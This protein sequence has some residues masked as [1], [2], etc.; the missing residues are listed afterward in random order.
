MHKYTAHNA[1]FLFHSIEKVHDA[2]KHACMRSHRND[3]NDVDGD[4]GLRWCCCN[5]IKRRQ[6]SFDC[7]LF[8]TMYMF[9][10]MVE[11]LKNGDRTKLGY[12]KPYTHGFIY[13]PL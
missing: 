10:L 8:S 6:D 7:S 4:G 2:R 3:V 1:R 12:S 13:E 5:Q 9:M 11:Q